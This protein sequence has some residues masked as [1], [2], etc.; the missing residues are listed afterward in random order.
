MSAQRRSDLKVASQLQHPMLRAACRRDLQ[1]PDQS[2]EMRLDVVLHQ[3]R[4]MG[5]ADDIFR[6]LVL[7]R[8]YDDFCRL[9]MRSVAV[10]ENSRHGRRGGTISSAFFQEAHV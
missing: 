4:R 10:A 8:R 2:R 1:G 5:E 9:K 7:V 6:Q 3:L